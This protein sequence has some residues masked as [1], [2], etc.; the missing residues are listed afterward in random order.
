MDFIN[1]VPMLIAVFMAVVGAMILSL[2]LAGEAWAGHAG[3][4]GVFFALVVAA[5]VYRIYNYFRYYQSSEG[6][7]IGR[8][9]GLNDASPGPGS[10]DRYYSSKGVRDGMEVYFYLVG[11]DN[12]SWYRFEIMFRV[13]NLGDT[14]LEAYVP[15]VERPLF[16]WLPGRV[17]PA[18]WDRLTVRSDQPERAAAILGPRNPRGGIFRWKEGFQRLSL[19]DNEFHFYFRRRGDPEQDFIALAMDEASKI[20]ARAV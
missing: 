13:A 1:R 3:A 4:A 17:R 2:V 9:L 18:G 15:F 10:T 19:D 11:A 12:S 16:R 20:A 8:A 7:P 14:R 6:A 5:G